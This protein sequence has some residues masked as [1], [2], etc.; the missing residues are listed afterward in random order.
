ME[1]HI[2][3]SKYFKYLAKEGELINFPKEKISQWI[4]NFV[5][6]FQT[7]VDDPPN[8]IRQLLHKE[9][10]IFGTKFGRILWK[11]NRYWRGVCHQI[12]QGRSQISTEGYGGRSRGV[13]YGK[14]VYFHERLF[15]A[16]KQFVDSKS[17]LYVQ[18]IIYIRIG[19]IR[20]H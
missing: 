8:V 17:R 14:F 9:I 1:N 6:F 20:D 5:T 3:Y 11:P 19:Y 16:I 10:T 7:Y 4:Y 13:R 12:G 18:I 2:Q 15:V